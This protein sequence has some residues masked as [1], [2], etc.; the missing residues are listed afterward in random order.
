MNFQGMRGDIIFYKF[1]VDNILRSLNKLEYPFVEELC[2]K[3]DSYQNVTDYE[4]AGRGIPAMDSLKIVCVI[5]G[6]RKI[7]DNQMLC[8]DLIAN[9]LKRIEFYERSIDCSRGKLPP[10]KYIEVIFTIK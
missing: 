6:T 4:I 10:H 8:D 9:N 7:I 2:V 5:N 3:S 1:T